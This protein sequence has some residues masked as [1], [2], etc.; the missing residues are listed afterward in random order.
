MSEIGTP[1]FMTMHSLLR[2]NGYIPISFL[3][4]ETKWDNKQPL[5]YK[6]LFSIT[7]G[8]DAKAKQLS[9]YQCCYIWNQKAMITSGIVCKCTHFIW[10]PS[11]QLSHNKILASFLFF[12]HFYISSKCTTPYLTNLLIHV[13]VSFWS[14]SFRNFFSFLTC[15]LEDQCVVFDSRNVL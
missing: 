2:L 4:M 3:K 7:I 10:Y 6:L 11:L 9:Q 13:I 12:W 14:Q 1:I 8:F 15:I 5:S